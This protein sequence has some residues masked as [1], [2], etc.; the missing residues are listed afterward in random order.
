MEIFSEKDSA[1]GFS[2]RRFA[3]I[4]QEMDVLGDNAQRLFL[5]EIVEEMIRS[6]AKDVE[7]EKIE[8]TLLSSSS[9]GVL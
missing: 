3:E 1:D 6:K 5:G 4:C 7:L 9:Y 2:L 8:R